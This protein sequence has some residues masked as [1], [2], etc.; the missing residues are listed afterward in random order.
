MISSSNPTAS[1]ADWRLRKL[2]SPRSSIN[3]GLPSQEA[4][5]PFA[6]SERPKGLL[7]ALYAPY[8]QDRQ[9]SATPRNAPF[10]I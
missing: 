2:R 3:G 1:F 6:A 10:A 5:D 4:S 7:H 9:R 8:V